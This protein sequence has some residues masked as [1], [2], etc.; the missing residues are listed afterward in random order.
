MAKTLRR[1]LEQYVSWKFHE[2]VKEDQNS[3]INALEKEIAAEIVE[4]K[5]DE[6]ARAQAEKIQTAEAEIAR[7]RLRLAR[8][9]IKDALLVGGIVGF[10]IGLLVNQATDLISFYKG[11]SQCMPIGITIGIIVILLVLVG[12]MVHFLYTHKVAGII[13][14]HMGRGEK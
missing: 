9:Q 10:L 3:I 12:A 6:M 7:E 2:Q 1:V 14:R 8:E 11:A 13:E 4:E 5:S